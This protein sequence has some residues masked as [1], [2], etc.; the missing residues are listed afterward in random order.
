MPN[1]IKAI[2]AAVAVKATQKWIKHARSTDHP[3]EIIHSDS[4]EFL[5]KIQG[6]LETEVGADV[7]KETVDNLVRL[8]LKVGFKVYLRAVSE[9]EIEQLEAIMRSEDEVFGAIATVMEVGLG[10]EQASLALGE[11]LELLKKH[12]REYFGG[13]YSAK[14]N[15]RLEQVITIMLDPD[16]NF[17][18][19]LRE[20]RGEELVQYLMRRLEVSRRV[21]ALNLEFMGTLKKSTKLRAESDKARVEQFEKMAKKFN[22]PA[23]L[24]DPFT[25]NE[26]SEQDLS[27]ITALNDFIVTESGDKEKA[28][29]IC[30]H[31]LTL[32]HKFDAFLT[33]NP[34][35]LTEDQSLLFTE[36][37]GSVCKFI[38]CFV[39]VS[40]D[41]N[42]TGL[43]ELM[44]LYSP[45][46]REILTAIKPFFGEKTAQRIRSMF[47]YFSQDSVNAFFFTEYQKREEFLAPLESFKLHLC[48]HPVPSD[49]ES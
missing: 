34:G 42:S 23:A 38:S 28:W 6:F 4:I 24:A 32:N 43:A 41:D 36:L 44:D 47:Y 14:T 48:A 19:K 21:L 33:L 10:P 11:P 35:E 26:L 49:S 7:A 1:N 18:F 9:E 37:Y 25:Q 12:L 15:A 20:R 31:F 30:S 17:L 13:T 46:E 29:K 22:Q 2:S 3:N 27:I 40:K 8:M 45:L 5:D 39:A 16:N